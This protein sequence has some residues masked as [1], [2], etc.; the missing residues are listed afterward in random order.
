MD[1]IHGLPSPEGGTISSTLHKGGRCTL[2]EC[3]R[4]MNSWPGFDDSVLKGA[5]K[6]RYA[7]LRDATALYL[8][9][10]PMQEVI[11]VAKV[12]QRRFLRI[13]SRCLQRDVSGQILGCRA[14]VKGSFAAPPQRKADLVVSA[15]GKGGFYGMFRK[16]LRDHPKIV[17]N[18][19]TLLNGHGLKGLRP[20]RLLFRSIHRSFRRICEVEGIGNN[21]YPL[22]TS[23]KARRALRSWIDSDYLPRY[24]SRYILLEHGVDAGGLAAYGEGDGQADRQATGYGA[25]IIDEVTVD[26]HARYEIPNAQG[27]WEQL[28]LRRFQELRV[29]H[30]GTSANLANRQ[31][32]APQ[33]SAEDISM[34]LWDAVSG[35][36]QVPRTIEGLKAE[37]GAGYPA[38]VIGE[39]RFG[40]P[41]VVYLD[42]ALAHLADH[43]QHVVGHLF[44]A[45]VILGKPKT[46]RERAAVESK[47]SLEARRVTHQL[48]STTGSGPNDPIRK[49][50]AVPI[51]KRV[52]AQDLEHVLDVYVMN[53]N[54]L[55]AAGSHNVPPLVR[56]RRLLDSGALKPQYLPTDKRKAYYFCRPEKVTVKVDPAAGRRPYINYLYQRYSSSTLSRRF[57]LKERFMYVRADF[58]NLRTVMLFTEDG[59]EFGPVQALGHWGTFPHD[60]RIRRLF[61]KLKRAGELETRADDRPLE[62]LFA[63]LRK[64]APRNSTA[65]LQ[66]S[67]LIQYLTRNEFQMGPAL[68]EGF[69]EWSLVSAA[70]DA[71]STL[72]VIALPVTTT[73]VVIPITALPDRSLHLASQNFKTEF[74]DLNA[75]VKPERWVLPRRSLRK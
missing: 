51:E 55:P 67:Y 70:T 3:Y 12:D 18:L 46:P 38:N 71:I 10:K 13:F 17:D 72:P 65:A 75:S 44:G 25:W 29:I 34:L 33:A 23:E 62:A 60:V 43:V 22:N 57:D 69:K 28:E 27:D 9:N 24:A 49:G 21:E 26:L 61:G 5:I 2:P 7:Q 42:N 8:A 68:A 54:A 32:Y 41:S 66:L 11:E 47:F 1:Q 30:K 56:L 52:R 36:E 50:S 15:D 64:K 37:D 48:P 4:D 59:R 40:V 16:L 58:R 53:E 73:N 19:I 14:F 45:T 74:E 39:L 6:K 20:N 35:P 63:H 31:I